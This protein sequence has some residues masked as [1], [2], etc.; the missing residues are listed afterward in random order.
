ML[1]VE[2][3]NYKRTERGSKFLIPKNDNLNHVALNPD[4]RKRRNR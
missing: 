3:T 4:F 2:N 1:G